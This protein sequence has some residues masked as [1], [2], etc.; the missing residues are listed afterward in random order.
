MK[1]AKSNSIQIDKEIVRVMKEHPEGKAGVE[2][3]VNS[4]HGIGRPHRL[5]VVQSKA[6]SHPGGC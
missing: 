6:V 4:V 1:L 2:N 5:H 3:K